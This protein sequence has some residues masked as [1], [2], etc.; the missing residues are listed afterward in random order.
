MKGCRVNNLVDARVEAGVY[1]E[2]WTLGPCRNHEYLVR[3]H[4]PLSVVDKK[5]NAYFDV[6]WAQ[7]CR[8]PCIDS[9]FFKWNTFG[10]GEVAVVTTQVQ[11]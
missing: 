3:P 7:H 2:H 11:L 6:G 5:F 1:R 4:H 10:P 8:T 9:G